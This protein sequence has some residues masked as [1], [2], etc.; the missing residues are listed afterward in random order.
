[1]RVTEIRFA[2]KKNLGDYQSREIE[3][4]A[5]VEENDDASAAINRVSNTVDWHL[6]KPEREVEYLKQLKLVASD[7]EKTRN[8]AQKYVE[9]FEEAR[10]EV[11]GV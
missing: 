3:L 2:Q 8:Y 6:N 10:L 1:M 11:E 4:T 5:C 9:R 7:D